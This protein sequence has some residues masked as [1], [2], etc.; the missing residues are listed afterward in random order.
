MTFMIILGLISLLFSAVVIGK[1]LQ[2]ECFGEG[3]DIL[4]YVVLAV[5][6]VLSLN[7]VLMFGHYSSQ[8]LN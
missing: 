6:I 7:L 3:L 1:L 4:E 2:K 5:F 8:V